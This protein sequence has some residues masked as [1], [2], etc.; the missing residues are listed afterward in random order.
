MSKYKILENKS[1][2]AVESDGYNYLFRKS[3]GFFARW[4]RTKEEE[5]LYSPIGPEIMDIEIT[6]K[7][8]GISAHGPCK[9]CYKSNTANG[10]NMSFD[11]FKT[12]LDKI[13]EQG[14]IL[15][16]IAYGVDAQAESNPDLW[17]M[18][19]YTRSKDI[20]PNITVAEITTE[21]ADKLASLC[22]AVAVSYYDL[23]TMTTSISKL[24]DS[25]DKLNRKMQIN[26]HA[27]IAEETFDKT[28]DLLKLRLAGTDSAVNEVNAFVLLSLKQK[29]RGKSLTRLSQDKFNEIVKFASENNLPIG[30]DSCSAFKFLTAVKDHK[31]YDIF[32]KIAE[33]CESTC[34]SMYVNAEGKFFPCSFAEDED[35]W[36]GID[37]TKINNFIDDVWYNDKV[38]E[39]RNK[40]ISCRSKCQNCFH[41]KL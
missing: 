3:D 33:P 25:C 8:K 27:L 15:T 14:K 6:T 32:K 34:F 19:E 5:V 18:M 36:E 39:Y 13:T 17:R 10:T 21:T 1:M 30:F 20:I 7:C 24:K 11:T 37:M 38:K 41:F 31:D 28:M 12:I 26:V 29:G 22:G 35:G 16:Q 23:S 40:I 2:K 9:F 4:G